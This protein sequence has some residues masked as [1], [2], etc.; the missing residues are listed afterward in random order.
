MS[1]VLVVGSLAYDSV[2]TPSGKAEKSLG[3]SANYFSLAASLFSRVRVVGVVGEDYSEQDRQI[4]L[5]REVDLTGLQTVA[6]KTFHWEGTYENNLN[7]AVTLKTELNVFAQFNPTLPEDYRDSAYVFLAN[8]DPTLQL[9]VL[10]Q[11][12]KPVFVG[13]DSMNFWIGSKQSELREVL[14]KVDIVFMND[15]EAKML[16]Q[17]SNTIT[18]IKKTA[19]LGPKYV[20]IKKGE[21]GATLYSQ[22]Y[23]FYQIPAL[24]VEN[25]VDPT[26]AGDSFAGGFFGTL[27]S[28]LNA[29]QIPEW[30]DLKAATLAGT[31]MSSQT[32]QDFSMKALIKVDQNLFEGQLV[33]LKQMIH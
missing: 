27:A 13:M 25:V 5:K 31:V 20:V 14:K 21:Y 24:P 32:I 6:G 1:A 23:G 22:K 3:G 2:K 11:V 17:T 18:A 12:K 33:Q 8:I 26:G 10:S 30:N 15:A 19:E 29:D 9:Q 7:E 28:R 4:L 16:T